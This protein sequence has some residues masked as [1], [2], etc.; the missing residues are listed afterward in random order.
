MHELC[1][2][3]TP[4][5][6][7]DAINHFQRFKEALK[8]CK[9]LLCSHCQEPGAGLGCFNSECTATYHYLCAKN[10]GCVLVGGK[11]IAFCERHKEEAK[12]HMPEVE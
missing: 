2:I 10:A 1:A 4:E 3:W 11:F 8:R 12:E 7:L 6:Y 5:I 9:K